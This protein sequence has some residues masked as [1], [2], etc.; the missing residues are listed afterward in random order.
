[1]SPTIALL[2]AQNYAE[3]KPIRACGEAAGNLGPYSVDQLEEHGFE[4]R[5]SD[6]IFERPW[7]IPLVERVLGRLGREF[8]ELLG[9]RNALAN[10]GLIARSDITVAIFEDQGSF[11]AFA[12]GH[13]RWPLSP[14]KMVLIVCWLAER[15]QHADARTLRGYRRVLTG[16]DLVV[17]FSENQA[18]VLEH[19]LGVD[20]ARLL[21]VPFGIDQQFFAE[22]PPRD[23]GYVLAVGGDPSRDHELLVEAVRNTQI[24]TRIYAPALDVANLPANVTWV[25]TVID[26]VTYRE[27]LSG[28]TVVVVPTIGTAYPGGQTVLLEA[29]ASSKPV[30]T[31]GSDAMRDYVT[32]GVNGVLVPRGDADAL[33]AAI[34]RLLGDDMLRATLASNARAAVEQKFNQAAMWASIAPRLHALLAPVTDS[35]SPGG[36]RR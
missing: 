36:G 18:H 29:M 31:T 5:Y 10:R 23:D 28:A 15:A 24:P 3:W 9:L 22:A 12:R 7:A 30:I 35:D 1:M 2:K 16:A 17:F 14:R 27:V 26:H 6:A 11:A 33:R 25:S 19:T 21:S 8:P 34:E 32:D 4:V 20:P 13:H